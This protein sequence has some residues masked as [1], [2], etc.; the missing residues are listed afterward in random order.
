MYFISLISNHWAGFVITLYLSLFWLSIHVIFPVET[1]FLGD[2]TSISSFLF[3]PHAV[4]VLSA[5]LLGPRVLFALIP[6]EIIAHSLW[7][8][9]FAYP[10]ALFIPIFSA[11]SA[12]VGFE[13]LRLAGYNVYPNKFSLPNW[14]GVIVAGIIASLFNSFT[15]SYLKGALI[16]SGQVGNVIIRYIIGDVAGLFVCMLMLII[17]FRMVHRISVHTQ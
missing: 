7:G 10:E 14:K 16:E 12:V 11:L 5:W 6:A 4:R 15:G 2:L 13:I 9:N 1:Y 3:L 8:L 17:I